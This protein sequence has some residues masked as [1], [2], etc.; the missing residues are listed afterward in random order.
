[1]R[2]VSDYVHVMIIMKI[3]I[4]VSYGEGSICLIML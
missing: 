1:M 3:T 4:I 2:N